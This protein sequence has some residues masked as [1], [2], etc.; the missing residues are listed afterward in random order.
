[1]KACHEC[2]ALQRAVPLQSG[3]MARC[4]RCG[5]VLYRRRRYGM[6]AT[7]ALT[8]AAA[9]LFVVANAFP[10][11]GME[12]QGQTHVTSLWGA[13]HSLWDQDVPLLALLVLVTT[14]VVPACDLG[15]ILWLLVPLS[16]GRRPPG[17]ALV[18][19][20]LLAI[21]PWGMVEV[22]M[23][24]V[25]VAL[26]KLAHIASV[27]PGV[28]LWSFGALIVLFAAAAATFDDDL[29]WAQIASAGGAAR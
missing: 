10:L 27:L 29:A 2:D 23:L 1:M 20:A 11:V 6:D 24:G 14:I 28:A 15:A 19:R 3:G 5:A 26:V 9:V 22:F 4:W 12:I 25:L 21:R 18:L 16:L 13:V 8:L 7:L 17:G